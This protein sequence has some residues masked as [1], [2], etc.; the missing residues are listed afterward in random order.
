MNLDVVCFGALN[1]DMLY[2]VNKFAKPG[3]ESIILSS[4]EY[5]GGSA[6]NTAVG[7]ARL[8]I[9]TGFIGKVANDRGGEIHI[10]SFKAKVA[11]DKFI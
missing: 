9:N 1:I 10:K 7:L 6:A 2:K 4:N 3:Y 8:G 5:P 11:L